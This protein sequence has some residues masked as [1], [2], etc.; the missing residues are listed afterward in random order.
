MRTDDNK[1][2]IMNVNT[3][4]LDDGNSALI[5]IDQTRLPGELHIL[6]LTEQ[7][8]IWEAIYL[9]KVRGAPA[10]GV[11]AA[12]GVY[13]IWPQSVS[14]P[15]VTTHFIRSLG[16]PRIIWLQHDRLRSIY[17]GR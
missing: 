11:A 1:I 8:D 16:K 17:S 9:L 3:V 13:L 14:K 5:I 7:K 12:I 2:N 6:Y 10:I 15:I 4:S